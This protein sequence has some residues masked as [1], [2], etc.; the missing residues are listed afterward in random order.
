MAYAL[1]FAPAFSNTMADLD[2]LPLVLQAA[3]APGER[4]SDAEMGAM[5]GARGMRP[6][7][8]ELAMIH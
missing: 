1:S 4:P 2:L 5:A 6:I 8:E 3:E 7:F